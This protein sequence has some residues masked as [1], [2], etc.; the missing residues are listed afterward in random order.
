MVKQVPFFINPGGFMVKKVEVK[1][2]EKVKGVVVAKEVD[3]TNSKGENVIS[4][5]I[6]PQG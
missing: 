5:S 1:K 2:V 3:A 6:H 4:K